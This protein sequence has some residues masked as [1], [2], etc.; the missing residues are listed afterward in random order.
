MGT[1]AWAT[2]TVPPSPRTLGSRINAAPSAWAK[3]TAAPANVAAAV[4]GCDPAGRI[5]AVVG[6]SAGRVVLA[7]SSSAADACPAG[8]LAAS[9]AS[10]SSSVR[11][12]TASKW[13]GV[14]WAVPSSTTLPRSVPWYSASPARVWASTYTTS[15]SI[16]RPAP[17][18]TPWAR[19]AG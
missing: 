16:G 8:R 4:G 11:E 12:A 18:T 17:A 9:L 5:G 2:K 1:V 10:V 7:P 15:A 19:R 13:A 3:A 14:G 6:A